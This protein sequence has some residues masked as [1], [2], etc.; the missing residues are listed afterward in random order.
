[1]ALIFSAHIYNIGFF[2]SNIVM[3]NILTKDEN[4]EYNDVIK[5][6]CCWQPASISL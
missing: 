3:V 6:V 2:Q 1:M 4:I 5:D